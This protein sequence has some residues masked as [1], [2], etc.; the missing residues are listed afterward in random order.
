V[1]TNNPERQKV[2]TEIRAQFARHER[3]TRW[4]LTLVAIS[5]I[6]ALVSLTSLILEL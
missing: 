1:P 4:I 2:V 5:M 3:A 6:L